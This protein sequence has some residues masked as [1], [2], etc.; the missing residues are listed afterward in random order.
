MPRN[1]ATYTCVDLLCI[2][3]KSQRCP[4]AVSLCTRHI[5]METYREDAGHCRSSTQV[6]SSSSVA[7]S[8]QPPSLPC[9]RPPAL[10]H[11]CVSDATCSKTLLSP[12]AACWKPLSLWTDAAALR[13][14]QQ[15]QPG[16]VATL[17]SSV[18]GCAVQCC[19]VLCYTASCCNIV[20]CRT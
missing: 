20:H 15:M 2:L 10:T 14:L 12:G 6:S 4:I 17:T 7:S 3:L 13:A 9:S 5:G 11:A 18:L 16:A 1:A 19:A 8:A